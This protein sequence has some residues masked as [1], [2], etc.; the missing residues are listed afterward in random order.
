M[1]YPTHND[2]G[3]LVSNSDYDSNF[4][5]GCAEQAQNLFWNS[6][7]IKSP[8]QENPEKLSRNA[9]VLLTF[10]TRLPHPLPKHLPAENDLADSPPSVKVHE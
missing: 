6:L 3:I 5:S 7:K 9:V 1:K 10:T 4:S 8:Q 2:A